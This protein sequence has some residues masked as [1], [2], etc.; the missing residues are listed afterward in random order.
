MN[1]PEFSDAGIVAKQP[2][3]LANSM[4][5]PMITLIGIELLPD[6]P[7]RNARRPV[8]SIRLWDREGPAVQRGLAKLPTISIPIRHRRAARAGN[9]GGQMQ[10]RRM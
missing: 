4:L 10:L 5:P 3:G 7:A 2:P 9:R 6:T 8:I 1:Y